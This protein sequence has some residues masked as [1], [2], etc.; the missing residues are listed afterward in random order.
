MKD[1][2]PEEFDLNALMRLWWQQR[3]LMTIFSLI[4][5]ILVGIIAFTSKPVFRA[6][7]VVTEARDRGNG[8]L[9]SLGSQ[10]GGLASLAGLSLGGGLNGNAQYAAILESR[11]LSE[12]FIKRNGLLPEL[13]EASGKKTLWLVVDYFHKGV[14]SVRKDLRKGITTIGIEWTDPATAARWANGYVALANELIRTRAI[15]EA[16]RNITYLNEQIAKTDVLELRKVL[17]SLVENE[18][19]TLMVANGRADYAFEVV[20]PAVAP[21][22][23]IG[24]H[25]LIMTL[26]GLVLGFALGTVVAFIRDRVQRHRRSVAAVALAPGA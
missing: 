5:A 3:R 18:T 26:I 10:L 8:G 14:L 13:Q 24:P 9:A 12:E 16:S 7:T 6:E 15:D 23:K 19:K 21:E 1:H 2:E 4:G 11:N 20:D 25:R 22:R 17:Y